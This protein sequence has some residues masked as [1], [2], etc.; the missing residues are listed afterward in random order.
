LADVT[1]MN[2]NILFPRERKVYAHLYHPLIHWVSVDVTAADLLPSWPVA[3]LKLAKESSPAP[4][5]SI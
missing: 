5:V 2:E 4:N 3:R 1:I